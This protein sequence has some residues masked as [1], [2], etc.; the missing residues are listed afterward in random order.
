MIHSPLYQEIVEE[1]SRGTMR[2]ATLDLLEVRFGPEAKDLEAL[3]TTI[4]FGRLR[5]LHKLA[6]RCRSL[7][8]FRKRLL[9]SSNGGT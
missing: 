9:S 4:A 6:A 1:T 2:Q 3:L 5:E 7:S 8:S